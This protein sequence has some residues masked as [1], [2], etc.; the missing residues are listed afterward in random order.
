LFVIRARGGEFFM[1]GC[2]AASLLF[3]VRAHCDA[4]V[5]C[6]PRTISSSSRLREG[7]GDVRGTQNV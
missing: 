3:T 4:F 7:G 1:L 6:G 2:K 5:V